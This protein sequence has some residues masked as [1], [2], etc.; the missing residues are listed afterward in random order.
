MSKTLDV[1]DVIKTQLLQFY[2]IIA[3]ERESRVKTRN[4]AITSLLA[5]IAILGSGKI[6]MTQLSAYA[7]LIII[8]LVFWMIEGFHQSLVIVNS[9]RV[10]LLEEFLAGSNLPSSL[11][12][13][14][15]YIGGYK[16]ISLRDKMNAFFLGSFTSEPI[17]F[18]YTSI[19][20]I[21]CL[22]VYFVYPIKIDSSSQFF[23]I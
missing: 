21:S 3:Q 2:S 22:F 8:T 23:G 18:F 7:T 9:D 6:Y 19:I 4:W 12:I 14:F 17:I 16:T 1:Q 11:P 5:Y 20:L 15:H 13:R 10:K